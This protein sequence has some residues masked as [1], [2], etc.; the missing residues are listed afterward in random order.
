MSGQNSI[1]HPKSQTPGERQRGLLQAVVYIA[2]LAAVFAATMMFA[3]AEASGG[4]LGKRTGLT[5][6]AT[7]HDTASLSW[8]APSTGTVAHYRVLRKNMT[9][10]G[11]SFSEAGTS[12]TT[13]YTDTGLEAETKYRY[14]VQA[15]DSEGQRSR[16]ST[17]KTV[18]T[19]EEQTAPAQVRNQ[20]IAQ[21]AE[22]TAV[23]VSWSAPE[24]AERCQLQRR[25][26]YGDAG[27]AQV[28]LGSTAISYEDTDT[29]YNTHY[30]CRVRAGNNAGYGACSDEASITT[31][32]EP[33]TPAAPGD[34]SVAENETGTVTVSWTAPE[35][36]EEVDGYRVHRNDISSG[37]RTV[38]GTTDG[39]TTSYE[40]STVDGESWY[41]YWLVAHNSVGNSPD[42][43]LEAIE[44]QVQTE[45]V[46]DAPTDLTLSEET[47]GE[48]VISWTGPGRVPGLPQRP[49]RFEPAT[50]SHRDGR[51]HHVHG[52]HRERGEVVRLPGSGCQQRRRERG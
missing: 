20:S 22:A 36:D 45:G 7:S 26:G 24:G 21:Q 42:S 33:G 14:R 9:L 23:T 27:L 32:R 34:V 38:I 13:D 50:N 30:R 3:P 17:Q 51:I 46:P 31:A 44:T 10:Q 19:P 52:R 1:L 49:Y 16:R 48:V 12:T 6:T 39:G 47:A 35:G 15:V 28:D 29:D 41:S 25:T 4:R 11:S 18:T 43:G 8:T 40:D 2:V 37:A 5:T